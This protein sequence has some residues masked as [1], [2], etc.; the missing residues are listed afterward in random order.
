MKISSNYTFILFILICFSWNSSALVEAQTMNRDLIIEDIE[1]EGN[2]KTKPGVI[3]RQMTIKPGDVLDPV[4]LIENTAR[5]EQTNFFKEAEI[6]TRPGSQKGLVIVVVEIRERTWPYYRFE[7]GHSDLNGWYIIPVSFRFDNFFG[8]GKLIGWQMKI[9]DRVSGNLITYRNPYLFNSKGYLDFE[10]YEETQEFIHYYEK[11]DTTSFLNS[12]GLRMKIGGSS[13]TYH[14]PFGTLRISY[15][16]PDPIREL[17]PYFKNDFSN[18]T[19]I[20]IGTGYQID[21]RDN[22]SYP[23]SGAWGAIIGELIYKNLS[24]SVIYPKFLFDARIYRPLRDTQVFAV[25][26]EIGHT[27][28]RAPFNERFYLGGSYS[29]RGYSFGRLTPL[30]WGNKFMLTQ[31]ELR[32]PLSSKDFPNHKHTAVTFFDFGGIWAPKQQPRLND[33]HAATGIGYRIKLPLLGIVRF[34]FSVRINRVGKSPVYLN[35]GLENTF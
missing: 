7:G 34:D 24:E 28:S 3:L 23:V 11:K 35:V 12:F 26:F 33:I 4:E 6:Y 8:Q 10:L 27:T 17:Y 31:L 21:T 15:N 2:K 13:G 16:R 1:I 22:Y 20:A 9:G 18:T 25:H 5:L 30:G 29:L 32:F 14:G 19:S